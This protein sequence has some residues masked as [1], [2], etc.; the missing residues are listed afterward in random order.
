MAASSLIEVRG[1]TSRVAGT[2]IHHLPVRL[3]VLASDT[4]DA[5]TPPSYAAE[6]SALWARSIA[7]LGA[8]P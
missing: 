6:L 1:L 2:V 5:Y 3:D 7:R 8:D 4:V